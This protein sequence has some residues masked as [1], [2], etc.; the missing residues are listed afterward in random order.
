MTPWEVI[1]WTIAIPM[2]L[3]AAILAFALVVAVVRVIAGGAKKSLDAKVTPL[4][5]VDDDV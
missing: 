1:G 4:R 5:K 2:V 3:F